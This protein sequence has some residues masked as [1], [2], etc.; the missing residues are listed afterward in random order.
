MLG[1]QQWIDLPICAS[2]ISLQQMCIHTLVLSFFIIQLSILKSKL[3][4]ICV[5]TITYL[6]AFDKFMLKQITMNC[7]INVKEFK[8]SYSALSIFGALGLF[9]FSTQTFT[10]ECDISKI[11]SH[12]LTKFGLLVQLDESCRRHSKC[13]VY[14]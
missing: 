11:T 9:H 8:Q 12:R 10:I 4:P 14:L 3:K 7:Q 1:F 13:S 6:V 5:C 2:I